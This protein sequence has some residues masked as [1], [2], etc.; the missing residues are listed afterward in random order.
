VRLDASGQTI[1][2]A[3]IALSAVAPTPLLAEAAS[4]FLV[5]KPASEDTYR[6]AGELAEQIANPIFDMRG[7]IEFRKNLVQVLTRR[8]LATAVERARAR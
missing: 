1:Q 3:R 8:T 5:G 6:Q 2:E 4:A 7:T